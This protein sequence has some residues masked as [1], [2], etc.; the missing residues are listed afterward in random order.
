MI[1]L[2]IVIPVY[3]EEESLRELVR[4][5][6]AAL[7]RLF[8]QPPTPRKKRL[9]EP[10]LAVAA[11][12]PCE[13]A[14]GEE[15]E[16][17]AHVL[18]R[19]KVERSPHW[20]GPHDRPI[21]DGRLDTRFIR[22]ARPQA[23]RPQAAFVVLCLYGTKFSNDVGGRRRAIAPDMLIEEALPGDVTGGHR[24]VP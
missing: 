24:P 18:G 5:I 2:S 15:R 8:E 13:N 9:F 14:R 7:E 4:Q 17:P 10:E 6:T 12:S 23:D 11:S 3:N 19:N 22:T 21:R 1:D 20:P 16:H